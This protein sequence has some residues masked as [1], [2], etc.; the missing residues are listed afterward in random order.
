M[1]SI[2][3]VYDRWRL[4]KSFSVFTDRTVGD[5]GLFYCGFIKGDFFIK[6]V[7][8]L[9]ARLVIDCETDTMLVMLEVVLVELLSLIV[10]V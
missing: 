1:S 3:R 7:G 10:I 9:Q 4:K 5:R 8:C 6:I 2:V